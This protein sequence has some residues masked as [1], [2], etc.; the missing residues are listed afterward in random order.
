MGHL[1]SIVPALLKRSGI[2]EELLLSTYAELAKLK[3]PDISR[4]IL[5]H[6]E[7]FLASISS[8]EGVL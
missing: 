5:Q 3:L 7:L 2:S 8:E 6:V 1:A 4:L